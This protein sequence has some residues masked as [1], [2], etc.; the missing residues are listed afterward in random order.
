MFIEVYNFR[1][2][3]DREQNNI[4]KQIYCYNNKVA[5]YYDSWTVN[6]TVLW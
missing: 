5:N 6:E 4:N 1:L 3:E 2:E